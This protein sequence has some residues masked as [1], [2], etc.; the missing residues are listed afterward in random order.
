MNF[1]KKQFSRNDRIIETL[2]ITDAGEWVGKAV[3]DYPLAIA[4]L[5][6]R[7]FPFVIPMWLIGRYAGN[8]GYIRLGSL[9]Y[10]GTL[11]A[12]LPWFLWQSVRILRN[13]SNRKK[14][15]INNRTAMEGNVKFK[16]ACQLT[17][18]PDGTASISFQQ[19]RINFAAADLL[20]ALPA[21]VLLIVGLLAS[22]VVGVNH[23]FILGL[24]TLFVVFFLPIIVFYRLNWTTAIISVEREGIRWGRHAMNYSDFDSIG[25]RSTIRKANRGPFSSTDSYVY[26]TSKGRDIAITKE[27]RGEGARDIAEALDSAAARQVNQL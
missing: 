4:A 8:Y 11:L 15:S 18:R 20:I 19:R 22:M 27:V 6:L 13:R 12:S 25:W 16:Q 24:L 17:T 5:L 26:I 9:L 3:F 23:G 2:D 10:Y 14:I 1:E 21:G 7:L